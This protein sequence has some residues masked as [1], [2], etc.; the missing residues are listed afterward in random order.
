VK[1]DKNIVRDILKAQGLPWD[2]EPTEEA[3]KILSDALRQQYRKGYDD[4]QYDFES[5]F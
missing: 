5:G 1:S 3:V 4:A 2:E